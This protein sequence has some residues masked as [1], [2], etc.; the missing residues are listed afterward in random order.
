MHFRD[1]PFRLR[2]F[3]QGF[4]NRYLKGDTLTVS[5]SSLPPPTQIIVLKPPGVTDYE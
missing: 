1:D 5:R 2:E 4:P 3:T